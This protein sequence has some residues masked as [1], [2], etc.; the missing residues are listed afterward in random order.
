MNDKTDVKILG[1]KEKKPSV[2]DVKILVIKE[3]TNFSIPPKHI[4]I[5]GHSPDLPAAVA[6]LE[7]ESSECGLDVSTPKQINLLQFSY[8]LVHRNIYFTKS[9][10]FKQFCCTRAMPGIVHS[11]FSSSTSQL[12]QSL[13]L[14][15]RIVSDSCESGLGSM[16][17]VATI[18]FCYHLTQSWQICQNKV[19]DENFYFAYCAICDIGTVCYLVMELCNLRQKGNNVMST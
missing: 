8:C 12:C 1:I 3:K 9:E 17:S 11:R 4:K 14:A 18:F 2:F 19:E 13:N 16:H 15:V 5:P 7:T 6:K 10:L